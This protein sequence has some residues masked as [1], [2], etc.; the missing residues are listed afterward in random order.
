MGVHTRSFCSFFPVRRYDS[1]KNFKKNR[2][3]ISATLVLASALVCV[4]SEPE[5]AAQ[6]SE[7]V[8]LASSG[9][10]V[11]VKGADTAG[12][13]AEPAKPATRP[14]LVRGSRLGLAFK[15]S[16]LGFGADL[17]VRLARPVNLRVGFSG[18]NYSRTVADGS[19]AY[20]G[21][22]HL[23][24]LQTVVDWFPWSRGFHLSP[25]VMVFNDNHATANALI[26]TGK[27]LTSG[28]EVFVSNPKNPI[29]GAASSSMRRVAPMVLFGFGNLV[30]RT[31]RFSVTSDFGV[32]FQGQPSTSF[33]LV[34][35]ACDTTGVHCRNVANDPSI[36][37]DVRSGE[38]TMRDDLSILKFYPVISVE[39]GYHF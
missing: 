6:T 14:D 31:R 5:T 11:A 26:P 13:A 10:D 34:G 18:F 21:T 39:F 4:I 37:A 24:S 8:S 9:D 29:T 30:P 7:K 2:R 38:Q 15:S 32:V 16:T 17:G 36:Q 20:L 27:T 23:R 35:S 25:G 12:K 28:A 22:L 1:C 33:S 19:I 3:W